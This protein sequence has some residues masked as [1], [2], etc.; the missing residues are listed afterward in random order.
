MRRFL[1]VKLIRLEMPFSFLYRM[2]RLLTSPVMLSYA[3]TGKIGLNSCW[4]SGK[5]SEGTCT[6]ATYTCG[7]NCLLFSISDASISGNLLK[8]LVLHTL[9][10]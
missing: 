1:S 5:Y 8:F 7:L 4:R 10:Y 3:N 2:S 6:S 9:S